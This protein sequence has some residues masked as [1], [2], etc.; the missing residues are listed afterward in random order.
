MP[1]THQLSPFVGKEQRISNRLIGYWLQ[2]SA[3]Q[4]LPCE[5]DI[6]PEEIADIWEHCFLIRIQPENEHHVLVFEYMGDAL[7]H[8]YGEAMVEQHFHSL[9]LSKKQGSI[10][11]NILNIIEEKT[12]IV[13]ESEYVNH[14]GEEVKYRMALV[15]F[16]NTGG[17]LSYVLGGVRWTGSAI[18]L[19]FD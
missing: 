15:P 1:T 18:A 9:S 13:E 6:N 16:A 3:H 12:P 8:S 11:S 2:L 14:A 5:T 4:S 10:F 7:L 19:P 17:H